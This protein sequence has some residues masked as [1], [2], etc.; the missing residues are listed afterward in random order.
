MTAKEELIEI[1]ASVLYTQ[2]VEH[3]YLAEK[4]ADSILMNFAVE[5]SE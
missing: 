2:V 3:Y 5:P 4:I 1:I